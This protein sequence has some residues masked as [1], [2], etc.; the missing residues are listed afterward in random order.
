VYDQ[1]AELSQTIALPTHPHVALAFVYQIRSNDLCAHDFAAIVINTT[2]IEMLD[3]CDFY[4]TADW[5]SGMVEL[6][7]F[8]GQT[9]T[10]SFRVTTDTA[11]PSDWYLD[12][13]TLIPV[14]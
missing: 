9:V 1:I 4:T 7:Q 5:H 2:T 11:L 12:D 14:P 3:L 6:N 8:A 10:I 13:I